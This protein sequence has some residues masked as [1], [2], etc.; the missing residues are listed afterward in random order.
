MKMRRVSFGLE[1]IGLVL[2]PRNHFQVMRPPAACRTVPFL[3]G[4]GLIN[5]S[6]DVAGMEGS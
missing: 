2:T 4:V 3:A 1:F 6:M 5:L